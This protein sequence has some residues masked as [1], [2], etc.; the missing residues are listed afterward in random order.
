MCRSGCVHTVNRTWK[1]LQ[2]RSDGECRTLTPPSSSL[3]D[4][5]QDSVLPAKPPIMPANTPPCTVY[6]YDTSTGTHIYLIGSIHTSDSSAD[7]V[8]QVIEAVKPRV[9]M[10]ELCPSR[11]ASMF[12]RRKE[13]P[14]DY[15]ARPSDYGASAREFP[16]LSTPIDV[17]MPLQIT[18]PTQENLPVS[19]MKMGGLA[20]ETLIINQ[21]LSGVYKMLGRAGL[22]P[23]RDFEAAVDAARHVGA[24]IVLGDRDVFTTYGE[25]AGLRDVRQAFDREKFVQGAS[26][27][28]SSLT[29]SVGQRVWLPDVLL[30]PERIGE[31]LPVLALSLLGMGL[32]GVVAWWTESMVGVGDAQHRAVDDVIFATPLFL[33]LILFPRVYNAIIGSRDRYLAQ[34]LVE[35]CVLEHMN[36]NSEDERDQEEERDENK[37]SDGCVVAVVGLLHV[38][39]MVRR[40]AMSSTHSPMGMGSTPRPPAATPRAVWLSKSGE[41]FVPPQGYQWACKSA[42]NFDLVSNNY[43]F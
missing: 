6:L 43:F 30:T 40:M 17:T 26:G 5:R 39:G 1:L 18:T 3:A 28:L 41:T 12:P 29:P 22:K 14:S 32:S 11:F 33:L 38:N 31:A 9:V 15:E 7:E 19:Q 21:A 36:D 42:Q 20:K 10:L 24:R 34:S 27:L 35:C 4:S 37:G 23:G 25:I 16:N 13:V 2:A 8:R